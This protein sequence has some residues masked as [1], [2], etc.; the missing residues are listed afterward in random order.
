MGGGGSL[1]SWLRLRQQSWKL[2]Q[3]PG[4][5][6]IGTGA[7]QVRLRVHTTTG[8]PLVGLRGPLQRRPA[9]R[10]LVPP[11]RFPALHPGQ[12]GKFAARNKSI[13]RHLHQE[14]AVSAEQLGGPEEMPGRLT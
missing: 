10:G 2:G 6:G 9:G 7:E 3:G 13:A 14:V 4:H 11:R 5:V 1:D 8:L 12:G